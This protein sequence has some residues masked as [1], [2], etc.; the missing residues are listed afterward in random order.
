MLLKEKYLVHIHWFPF[1]LQACVALQIKL[2][3]NHFANYYSHNTSRQ[4]VDTK[5]KSYRYNLYF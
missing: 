4:Q 3:V 1:R 2:L 5:K